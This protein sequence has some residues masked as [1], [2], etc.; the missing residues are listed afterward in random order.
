MAIRRTREERAELWNT[1]SYFMR[2]QPSATRV[3]VSL[4][5]ERNT[6]IRYRLLAIHA[7]GLFVTG[8]ERTRQLQTKFRSN[9][10]SGCSRVAE[11]ERTRLGERSTPACTGSGLRR[12]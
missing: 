8:S 6:Y 4:V 12:P 7:N 5:T 2:Y 11:R 3:K 9:N 10:A 1:I